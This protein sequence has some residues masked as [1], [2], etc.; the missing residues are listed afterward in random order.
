MCRAAAAAGLLLLLHA[1]SRHDGR[2]WVEG[3]VT[4]SAAD[5]LGSLT[6]PEPSEFRLR[7]DL[8]HELPYDIDHTL[9][10]APPDLPED[11]Q[12][13]YVTRVD[14]RLA[15]S[16]AKRWIDDENLL[17]ASPFYHGSALPSIDPLMRASPFKGRDGPLP[18]PRQPFLTS[19]APLPLGH[20][21]N[22]RQTHHS[23]IDTPFEAE[24]GDIGAFMKEADNRLGIGDRARPVGFA[25]DF[26]QLPNP[27]DAF[28]LK[29]F[30][31]SKSRVAQAMR[32]RVDDDLVHAD[33]RGSVANAGDT[34]QLQPGIDMSNGATFAGRD[35]ANAFQPG[36]DYG[37]DKFTMALRCVE[38]PLTMQHARAA[39]ISKHNP[40]TDL[41][42]QPVVTGGVC[43]GFRCS[44]GVV[45]AADTM[46]SQ[47]SFQRFLDARRLHKI[48][49]TIVMAA[50]GEYADFQEMQM[51][52]QEYTEE[53]DA[54]EPQG[55][56]RVYP[57]QVCC[58][59]DI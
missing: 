53:Y 40:S 27:F 29:S 23:A 59:L 11:L 58:C 33:D 15:E 8:V 50:D 57:S 31:P 20:N 12:H 34:S 55:V 25:H 38:D 5:F 13:P 24:Y 30:D 1:G 52:F 47:G 22:L 9:L 16:S 51:M 4:N 46:L 54:I 2:G 3:S 43:I 28:E 48:S 26:A 18:T 37:V 7:P 39:H 10:L 6:A 45:I 49:D 32:S 41:T 17:G 44:D 36:N 56:Y 42:L 19:T 35:D 14:F 21:F